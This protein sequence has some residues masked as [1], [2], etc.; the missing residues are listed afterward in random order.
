MAAMDSAMLSPIKE[1]EVVLHPRARSLPP[2]A[3]N[4]TTFKPLTGAV[5][6]SGSATKRNMKALPGMGEFG[7][8]MKEKVRRSSPAPGMTEHVAQVEDITMDDYAQQV[9]SNEVTKTMLLQKHFQDGST[10]ISQ[11]IERISARSDHLTDEQAETIRRLTKENEDM[12]MAYASQNQN[13]R[14]EAEQWQ[15]EAL[16]NLKSEAVYAAGVSAI[17]IKALE[18]I[19]ER[20]ARCEKF[21]RVCNHLEEKL[22][23]QVWKTSNMYKD[24]EQ[25]IASDA[26]GFTRLRAEISQAGS[27]LKQADMDSQRLQVAANEFE[28]LQKRLPAYERKYQEMI[29]ERDAARH[30]V[31]V[32]ATERDTE[33][34]VKRNA[35]D[36][37]MGLARTIQTLDS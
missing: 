12:K 5:N 35:M 4:P 13:L 30:R 15:T 34:M 31:G 20:D 19:Q 27:E 18:E 23:E 9:G 2:M 21:S 11:Y 8:V 32:L 14:S 1:T 22:Q 10:E 33:S 7:P 6:R 36:E 24:A 29:S 26:E 17:G 25:R 37:S 28:G 3:N 16:K